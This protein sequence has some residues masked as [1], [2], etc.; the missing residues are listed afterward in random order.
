MVG[1]IYNAVG[2]AGGPHRRLKVQQHAPRPPSDDFVAE[3]ADERG[4]V[5]PTLVSEGGVAP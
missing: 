3:V 4:T 2:L 5:L 1:R